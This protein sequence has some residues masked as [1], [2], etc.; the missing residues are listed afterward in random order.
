MNTTQQLAPAAQPAE[1]PRRPE[2]VHRFRVG[3]GDVAAAG[4]VDGATLLSWIDRAAHRTAQRWSGRRCVLVSVGNLHPDRPIVVGERVEVRAGLVYT[5]RS[6][7]HLLITVR[8]GDPDSS[9]TIQTAHCAMIFAAADEAGTPAE[10]PR[11]TPLTMLELQ[12][13]RQARLRTRMRRRIDDA[14]CERGAYWTRGRVV[15]S[16]LAGVRLHRPVRVGAMIDVSAPILYTGPRS[17]H[18]GVLVSLADPATGKPQAVARA[19]VAVVS[20]DTTGAAR[21]VPRWVP[22]GD[23]ERRLDEHA[24]HLIALRAS[25][26]PFPTTIAIS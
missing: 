2:T 1:A 11:W 18:V 12:R 4:N 24:R 20:L 3:S 8:S 7:M 22:Q 26:E 25:I 10:V 23:A 16:C 6:S 17:V 15:M 19:M 9:R 14:A 21:S 5:G 13:H